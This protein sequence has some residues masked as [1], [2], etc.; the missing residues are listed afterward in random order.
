MGR[1]RVFGHKKVW[2]AKFVGERM[3]GGFVGMEEIH[4]YGTTGM[5]GTNYG[6]GSIDASRVSTGFYAIKV[7]HGEPYWG[8][9]PGV[10]CPSGVSYRADVTGKNI[11]SG[12]CFLQIS[13]SP[14]ST[15]MATGLF[16]LCNPC[17][18][19]TANLL[20]MVG[21]TSAY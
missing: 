4:F 20:V 14:Q 19:V 3:G 5:I 18:G 1:P 12:T 7:P 17:S 15:T 9:I 8:I 2:P 11:G 10:E 13:R 16:E 6:I 21:A